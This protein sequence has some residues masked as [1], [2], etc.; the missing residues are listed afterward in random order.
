MRFSGWL[1]DGQIKV[2]GLHMLFCLWPKPNTCEARSMRRLEGM[3]RCQLGQ[4]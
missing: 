3:R 4:L 2:V 1:Y